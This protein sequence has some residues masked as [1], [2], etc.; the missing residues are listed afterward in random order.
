MKALVLIEADQDGIKRSSLATINAASQLTDHIDLLITGQHPDHIATEAATLA[1]VNTVF[2]NRHPAYHHG[3]ATNSSALV[4]SLAPAYSFILTA[5]TTHGK[6]IMP[7]VAATLDVAQLSDITAIIDQDTFK[8]P[9]YAGNVIVTVKSLDSI[10]VITVRSTCFNANLK[11]NNQAEIVELDTVFETTAEQFISRHTS[12]TDQPKLTSADIIVSGGRAFKDSKHF[13]QLLTPLATKLGAAIGASR[14]AVDAGF[15]S[16]DFQIGQT[17][18]VVAPNVYFAIG[19]SGAIQHLAG[20]L[21]SNIIVAI[22]KDPNAN[23]HTIASYSL[24][25]D[26]FAIVP[27]LTD[28]L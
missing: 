19:I 23:I 24:V 20:I 2:T 22:N 10:K 18:K 16:N 4:A 17:G 12:R 11:R 27:E 21:D 6:N 13:S 7:R 26:L 1:S 8:R 9:I 14:A 28:K 3:L 25:G 5:A 15:I